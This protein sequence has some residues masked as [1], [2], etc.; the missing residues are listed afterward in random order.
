[1]TATSVSLL[2]E[3]DYTT[4]IYETAD[5]DE[6]HVITVEEEGWF[7]GDDVKAE[8]EEFGDVY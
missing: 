1:M 4:G 7:D 3:D 5:L 2:A 8:I 6:N